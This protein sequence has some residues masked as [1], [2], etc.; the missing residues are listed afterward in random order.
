MD[1]AATPPPLR[2]ESAFIA[3]DWTVLPAEQQRYLP[4]D[5]LAINPVMD[6]QETLC[7]GLRAAMSGRAAE[8]AC[9]QLPTAPCRGHVDVR[10]IRLASAWRTYG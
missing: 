8:S 1:Q 4:P 3:T 2:Q 10:A 7:A 5:F 9:I 6:Q